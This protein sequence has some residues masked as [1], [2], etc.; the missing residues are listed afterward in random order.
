MKSP[1]YLR[2]AGSPIV[3]VSQGQV[4]DLW[5]WWGNSVTY[6]HGGAVQWLYRRGGRFI[7]TMGDL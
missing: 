1:R 6:R 3:T 7:D 5:S 2:A 4:S